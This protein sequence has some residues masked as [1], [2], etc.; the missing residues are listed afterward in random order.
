MIGG[1]NACLEAKQ[2][3]TCYHNVQTPL[4]TWCTQQVYKQNIDRIGLLADCAPYVHTILNCL[5]VLCVPPP[6]SQMAPISKTLALAECVGVIQISLEICYVWLCR[7]HLPNKFLVPNWLL[8]TFVL[9]AMRRLRLGSVSSSHVVV[10]FHYFIN[11]AMIFYE[12]SYIN[13]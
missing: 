13:W 8:I 6:L 9:L 11:W 12:A 5:C 7:S 4:S 3:L 10:V 1:P 2:I